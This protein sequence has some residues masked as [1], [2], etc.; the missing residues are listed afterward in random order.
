MDGTANVTASLKFLNCYFHRTQLGADRYSYFPL[1]FLSVSVVQIVAFSLQKS[2]VRV[3]KVTHTIDCSVR[4]E[5]VIKENTDKSSAAA[6]SV[7]ATSPIKKKFVM[8]SLMIATDDVTCGDSPCLSPA[9]PS[10]SSTED[11]DSPTKKKQVTFVLPESKEKKDK[12]KKGVRIAGENSSGQSSSKAT[13][14]VTE[15][16][17]LSSPLLCMIVGAF[18]LWLVVLATTAREAFGRWKRDEVHLGQCVR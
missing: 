4:G 5:E 11:C 7:A 15:R 9:S 1:A 6:V 3:I 2:L 14:I 13:E 17:Y 10:P 12:R 8:P 18:L 16:K